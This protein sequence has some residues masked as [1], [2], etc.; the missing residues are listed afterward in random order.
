[1]LPN[2]QHPHLCPAEEEFLNLW[3]DPQQCQH[4][5][6]L[7][8]QLREWI[9]GHTITSWR[10]DDDGLN[11]EESEN[12]HFRFQLG[13]QDPRFRCVFTQVP[14]LRFKLDFPQRQGAVV[15]LFEHH[16]GSIRLF[17]YDPPGNHQQGILD[18]PQEHDEWQHP[19]NQ[20]RICIA[21]PLIY[22]IRAGIT[23]ARGIWEV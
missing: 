23:F 15:A 5:Q 10:P 22:H 7:Y 8:L 4:A 13:A 20:H 16:P 3:H 1:M 2:P 11:A 9:V 12:A 6:E 14:D 19:D 17:L 21:I 18:L